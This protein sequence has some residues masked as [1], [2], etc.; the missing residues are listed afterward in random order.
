MNNFST[1]I[2]EN[3]VKVVTVPMNNTNAT[4]VLL[5]FGAGS[6]YETPNIAGSSHL[7]EHLLFKGKHLA[8]KGK[9]LISNGKPLNSTVVSKCI[10]KEST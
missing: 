1:I 5:L 3:G 2:L 8:F 10:S 4:T 9:P 6:R 7:F